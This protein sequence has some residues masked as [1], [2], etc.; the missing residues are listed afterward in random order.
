MTTN[1]T[2]GRPILFPFAE[3]TFM[4]DEDEMSRLF[5][6]PVV[7]AMKVSAAQHA[8]PTTGGQ[9]W[10]FP[11]PADLPLVVMARMSLSFPGLIAAVPLYAVDHGGDGRWR[12]TCSPTAAS[13]ATSRCTSSTPAAGRG[14]R[15]A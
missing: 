4:F 1:L 13:A 14:R 9:L 11:D 10:H 3:R 7:E 15:S 6:T 8:N 12:G 5:P 2:L